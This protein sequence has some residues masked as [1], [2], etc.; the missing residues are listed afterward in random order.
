M[1]NSSASRAQKFGQISRELR[2]ACYAGLDSEALRRRVNDA[3][4]LALSADAALFLEI[5]PATSVPR[6]SVLFGHTE[7]FC[8]HMVTSVYLNGPVLDFG[9]R[10]AQNVGAVRLANL[11]IE[12]ERDA[13]ARAMREYGFYDDL[14]LVIDSRRRPTGFISAARRSA[15]RFLPADT[16]LLDELSPHLAAGLRAASIKAS[17]EAQ[18]GTNVAIIVLDRSGNLEVANGAAELFLGNPSATAPAFWDGLRLV[19]ALLEKTLDADGRAVPAVSMI[20][21]GRQYMMRAERGIGAD[22]D[23]RTIVLLEPPRNDDCTD[24]FAS[25]GLSP[26]E[27]QIAAAIVRGYTTADISTE[28]RIS[29]NT[30]KTH[31]R[32]IFEKLGITSRRE[33]ALLLRAA[34]PA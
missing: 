14:Q 29:A 13:Y 23:P 30:I 25:F 4:A 12:H 1:S 21:G 11:A 22:G 24:I 20:L 2:S 32:V 15:K 16:S 34:R 27:S 3:L 10:A 31:V 28:L 17:I 19:A 18:P 26:R 7:S 9:L 6:S 33:L 8:R 5:D